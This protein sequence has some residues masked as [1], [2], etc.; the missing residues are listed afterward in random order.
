MLA[1]TD[2]N[3]NVALYKACNPASR[4]AQIAL[5]MNVDDIEDVI[6]LI[7]SAKRKGAWDLSMNDARAFL[8][9]RSDFDSIQVHDL[10]KGPNEE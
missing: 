6:D 4:M 7:S 5:L 10:L 3:S 8:C 9:N 1:S 2:F